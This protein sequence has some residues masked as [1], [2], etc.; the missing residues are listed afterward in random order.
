MIEKCRYYSTLAFFL[1]FFS[2]SGCAKEEKKDTL[3]DAI[4]RDDIDAIEQ[5]IDDGADINER[6]DK[7]LTPLHVA[8]F[9]NKYEIIFRDGKIVA[10][11]E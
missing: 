10:G 3:H 1:I 4:R 8:V 5:L 7:D 6:N 11:N 2:V 9:H